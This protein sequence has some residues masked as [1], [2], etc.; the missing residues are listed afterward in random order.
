[1]SFLGRSTSTFLI[2]SMKYG[3]S[4]FFLVLWP[5][6]ASRDSIDEMV[7]DFSEMRARTHNKYNT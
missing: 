4:E 5:P 3:M 2:L 1:M 6:G 7:K